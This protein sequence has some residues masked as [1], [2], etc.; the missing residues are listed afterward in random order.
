MGVTCV[1]IGFT[2]TEE[3][4]VGFGEAE[5]MGERDACLPSGTA[6]DSETSSRKLPCSPRYRF[7]AWG[8]HYADDPSQLAILDC[9]V[10]QE[11]I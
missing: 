9:G 11:A 3:P 1:C 7:L 6:V 4:V 8:R 10:A 2:G 5:G